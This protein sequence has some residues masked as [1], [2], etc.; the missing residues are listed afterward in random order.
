MFFVVLEA[1]QSYG[2]SR[3]L[4]STH[5]QAS[6]AS[7]Y[8]RPN[9]QSP[10]SIAITSHSCRQYLLPRLAIVRLFSAKTPPRRRQI[11]NAAMAFTSGKK[12]T[13][14]KPRDP[15]NR[16]NAH[17]NEPRGWWQSSTMHAHGSLLLLPYSL[18]ILGRVDQPTHGH[19]S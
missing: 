15:R 6:V 3:T 16:R 13:K 9:E 4:F 12:G 19:T 11:S 7:F 1:T 17:P 10:S 8:R 14:R 2:K 18:C 5:Y